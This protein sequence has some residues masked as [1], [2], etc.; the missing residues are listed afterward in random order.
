[1][2]NARRSATASVTITEPALP[3][4]IGKYRVLKRLGEGAT[5]EVFLAR[6]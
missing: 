4:R 6:D 5:S 3:A 1:M 2:P